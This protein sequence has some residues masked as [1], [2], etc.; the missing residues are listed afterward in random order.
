M[1]VVV[2]RM[3]NM[4]S[5]EVSRSATLAEP[6]PSPAAVGTASAKSAAQGRVPREAWLGRNQPNALNFLRLVFAAVVVFSHTWA[7]GGMGSDPAASI[8]SVYGGTAGIAV[9]GFFLISGFLIV[10]SWESR[11]SA[12]KYVQARVMRIWPAFAVAFVISA[13]LTAA[14]AGRDSWAYLRSIPLQSWCVGIFTLD[15]LPL[16]R[17]LAFSHNPYPHT[18]NGPMWTIHIEFCCYLAVALAGSLGLFRRRTLILLF[19]ALVTAFAVRE[20]AVIPDLAWMRWARFA[21]FFSAGA[22]FYLYRDTIIR[23]KWIALLAVA[24]LCVPRLIPP[25]LSTPYAGGYLLFYFAFGAPAA[26]R[27]IGARND[28]SYGLYLYGGLVQQVLFAFIVAKSLHVNPYTVFAVS[29]A[30]AIA[31]GWASWLWIEKPAKKWSKLLQIS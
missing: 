20:Q 1:S 12:E 15:P 31:L 19:S 22:V 13:L 27:A 6:L 17:A 2:W 24:L 8:F 10:G 18:V 5:N 23:S 16:N 3:E 28:I 30:L 21:S 14:S 7:F 4:D 29:L 11:R 26:I 9:N 25:T